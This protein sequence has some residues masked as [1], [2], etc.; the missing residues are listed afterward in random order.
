MNDL[1]QKLAGT[2]QLLDPILGS[3]KRLGACALGHANA[4]AAL[5]GGI[6]RGALHE[7]FVGDASAAGFA[8]G[9][10]QRVRAKK[11]LL[12]IRQDFSALEHAEI[13]PT[14]LAELGIDPSCVLLL[15]AAHAEDAL[16]ASADALSCPALG[17]AIVEIPGNPKV[18]DLVAS[19]R[20]VLGAQAKGVTVI[21]LRPSAEAEPSA[22]E[23][24]WLIRSAPSA[25]SDDWGT[26]RFDAEL[27]RNRQGETGRWVM[28][29]SCDDGVFRQPAEKAAHPRPL[30]AAPA[31]RPP[32]QIE[33]RLAG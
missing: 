9:L 26:P 21:L 33:V 14:G 3:S 29:W 6:A 32:A 7:V 27:T 25:E 17:A 13:S 18:L 22:A 12:W 28:E 10:A 16:R 5:R 23:T 4:D 2:R 15:R 11:K 31:D 20:L 24:R 8:L 1:V 19:R 30:A